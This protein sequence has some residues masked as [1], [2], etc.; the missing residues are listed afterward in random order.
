MRGGRFSRAPSVHAATIVPG[1]DDNETSHVQTGWLP[2][3]ARSR[4]L[5]RPTG[6]IPVPDSKA[7]IASAVFLPATPS[8][9]PI[10]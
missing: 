5:T 2:S 7:L 8:G 6:L 1:C 4:G 3:T 10:S 9:V